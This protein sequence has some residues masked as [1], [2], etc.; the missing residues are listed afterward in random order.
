MSNRALFFTSVEKLIDRRDRHALQ[1]MLDESTILIRNI[2]SSLQR[3]APFWSIFL[4]ADGTLVQTCR[5]VA[6]YF[7]HRCRDMVGQLLWP[8]VC[9]GQCDGVMALGARVMESGQAETVVIPGRYGGQMGI[10]RC[11]L[12]WMTDTLG[13]MLAVIW[14]LC[15]REAQCR[16]AFRSFEGLRGFMVL[17]AGG[18]IWAMDDTVARR[19]GCNSRQAGQVTVY[20]CCH[21]DYHCDQRNLV[22][23]AVWSGRPSNWIRHTR[24]G[25]GYEMF[26]VPFF[27]QGEVKLLVVLGREVQTETRRHSR[28]RSFMQVL[29]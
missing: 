16:F 19:L 24:E 20:D 1:F 17:D 9:E 3:S 7:G 15:N 5:N 12:P 8:M 4:R 25:R 27:E 22:R 13:D 29:E 18:Q 14:P 21:Q 11:P 26:Q 6:G 10:V 28:P 2:Q 23:D